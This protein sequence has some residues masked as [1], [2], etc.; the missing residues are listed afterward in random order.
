MWFG[1]VQW[2]LYAKN[3][4]ALSV[5]CRIEPRHLRHGTFDDVSPFIIGDDIW[6]SWYIL[7]I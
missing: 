7:Y 2:E 6:I 5:L 4:R 3:A 1:G